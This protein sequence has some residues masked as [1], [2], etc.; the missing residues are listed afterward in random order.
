VTLLPPVLELDHVDFVRSERYLLRDVSLTVRPGDHWVLIGP[1]GAGKTTLLRL[2]GA[3]QHPT[4]GTV[5]VLGE[6]LG[7]VDMRALRTAIGH[8]DPRHPLDYPLT[9]RDVVLTGATNTVAIQ[10]RW[11]PSE[12]ELAQADTLIDL[13][14]MTRFAGARWQT[15]SSGHRTRPR[16]SGA[17][18][19]GPG[20]V[21]RSTPAVSQR[22]RHPSPGGDPLQYH[23]RRA[24]TRRE[25]S[26]PGPRPRRHHQRVGEQLLRSSGPHSLRRRP[27]DRAH[28][29][30]R[31]HAGSL[32]SFASPVC[33]DRRV[34]DA[35]ASA[36]R[37][38]ELTGAAH[39][40]V[41]IVLGSGWR[42]AAD[43]LG[44]AA[45]SF[46]LADLGG[47]PET[48]VAGHSSEVRSIEVGGKRVLA[49]LGRIHAYEGHPL[50]VVVH[51][52]R[53]ACA[54]GASTIVLTNAAGGLRKG[55]SVGQPVL[56]S[57][58]LNM[59]GRTALVGPRFI[60]LTEAYSPRLRAIAR[61]VDPTLEE[62][63]YAMMSGPQFETP[64][65]IRALQ[66]LGADLVGMSTVYETVAARAEDAEV[67]AFSLVTNLAAGLSG[68]LLN[69]QEVLDAGNAAATRMGTL[70]AEIV[71]QL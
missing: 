62:G 60:D 56:I 35:A 20:R 32:A 24:A 37:L 11:T 64:A 47:F 58:H 57:D 3:L 69:H 48:G 13:L 66:T 36:A 22:A 59:T 41:A 21:T 67:L 52:V 61:R 29:R 10:Q 15:L 5:R 4:G 42:P 28:R 26:R 43:L 23:P 14:G 17:A 33:D 51:A 18:P 55:L 7:K 6:Q 53:T 16:R 50:D 38:A 68:E 1:N 9:V 49:F 54:A 39:H 31:A 27:L 70:L 34:P 71:R 12:Q 8:V 25:S 46:D 40:D 30:R 63:V 44:A 2:L 45:A 65:E 19:H